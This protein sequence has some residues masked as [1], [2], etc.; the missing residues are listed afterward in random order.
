[1]NFVE[2]ILSLMSSGFAFVGEMIW[3]V[4]E[5]ISKPLS[6]L[7]Y[8]LDGVFYFITV[9]FQ[10]AIR[11]IMIFVA[12]FQFMGSLVLGLMRTLRNWLTFRV[13]T[14]Y[15]HYPSSSGTGIETLVDLVR[16]TGL[17]TIVPMVLIAFIWFF[18]VLKLI[19]LLGGSRKEA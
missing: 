5:F 16:P 18:F 10:I 6:Y 17:L 9:L 14:S 4:V 19:G 12:L 15:V 8:F 3:K 11:I 2:K 7:F 1:M 13:D